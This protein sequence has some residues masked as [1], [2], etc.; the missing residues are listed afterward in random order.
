M[1]NVRAEATAGPGAQPR[2]IE[3]AGWAE[4][5][6][7]WR[8]R[9]ILVAVDASD[10]ANR[11]VAEAVGLAAASNARVT[12]AHVYAARMHDWRFRQME[13]G[14]PERYR[15]EE[16]LAAQRDVHNELIARG[17]RLITDSYLEQAERA[18][19]EKALAFTP[20]SLE[21]KNYR[22]LLKEVNSGRHDLLVLGARGLGA[23]AGR[24]LGTVCERVARRSAIDTLVVKDSER[25]LAQGPIAVAVD[26]SP[27]SYGGLRTALALAS[28]W[29]V[30][31]EVLAAFDSAFHYAAFERINGALSSE[32]RAVFRF[33]EQKRLHEEIIDSGLARIYQG[34]LTVARAIAG[35]QG[36]AIETHLLDGKS[37]TAIAEH[38]R[39]TKPALLV[40]GKLGIH[41]DAE[42]DIGGAAEGL[43]READCAVLLSQRSFTPHADLVAEVTTV[44]TP[45]AEARLARIPEFVRP[46]ARL[47]ILRFAQERAHTVITVDLVSEAMSKVC[48]H[49]S[50]RRDG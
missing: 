31:V 8:Y 20:C 49:A 17:L 38:L 13:G 43:L 1:E 19:R 45:E 5:I 25:A 4:E 14:L 22:E 27:R 28:D 33:E 23:T 29:R 41:A 12:A 16:A 35:E 21:G 47:A 15:E 50:V 6:A 10:H 44:W 46:M 40:V 32:A 11:A 30:P 42:L 39:R 3:R 37:L 7:S 2:A 24:G 9:N 36:A 34:H 26:G 18:C 48:P